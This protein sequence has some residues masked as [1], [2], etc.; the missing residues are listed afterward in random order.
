M[1][2]LNRREV[3]LTALFAGLAIAPLALPGTAAAADASWQFAPALAPP[4]PVGAAPSPYPVALGR[5]GDIEFWAPNRGV[6]ITAGTQT[7]FAAGIVPMGVYAYN[8]ADWHQL[9]TVCGGT[10]GKIAWAGPDEFWTIADQRPGQVTAQPASLQNVSLCHFKDGA[11]VGS[12]AMPL[13]QPD[14]YQPMDAAACRTANDCWFAGGLATP[15]ATGGFHLHWDGSTVT[16]VYSPQNQPIASLAGM[17]GQLFESGAVPT[18]ANVVNPPAL[19]HTIAVPG[20][21]TLFRDVVP[22]DPACAGRVVCPPLPRWGTD[23][24]GTPVDVTTMRP[25]MLSTDGGL[26]AAPSRS[27]QLWAAN[28]RDPFSP[29]P[30]E[31]TAPAHPIVL[32]LA[33]GT[34]RQVVSD[35]GTFRDGRE[36]TAIAAE[37]GQPDAWVSLDDGAFGKRA[38]VA[39]VDASGEVPDP[40]ELG[41]DQG[42]GPRG[43]AGA[44][45]CPAANDCWMATD[46][47]WLFHLTD[48]TRQPIDSDP[49][50]AGVITFRPP[51]GG[52]PFA[53][54]D[55]PPADTSLLNQKPPQLVTEPPPGEDQ[56]PPRRQRK[57]K[58]VKP[59]VSRTG[60]PRVIRGTTTLELP[61][62]LTAKARVQLIASLHGKVV[63]RSARKVLPRGR[64]TIRA[65]LNPKRWP[66]RINL[67]ATPFRAAQKRA[68]KRSAK[69]TPA[70]R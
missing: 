22:P 3:A 31:R 43:Q 17:Q 38:Y 37:P 44:I 35:P 55:D 42:V 40:V 67:R 15:P 4:P 52:I 27:P 49:N 24:R 2:L 13:D 70:K 66:T 68:T 5:V 28:A 12:Y 54:P 14:S 50:F 11:V 1:T 62:T 36:P 61:F 18:G 57:P 21:A 63:A 59:L 10:D 32:R 46:Q 6:L 25:F 41:P 16:A 39:R 20:S 9:S 30:A 19:L 51:D 47:G 58:K 8:G 34:W 60:R 64:H 23:E 53:P 69:K 56:A 29:S 48:G 7:T 65:R 45:A 33:G 26:S